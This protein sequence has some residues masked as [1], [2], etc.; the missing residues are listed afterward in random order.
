MSLQGTLKTLGITEVLE[1]LSS[2]SASGRLDVT[3]EMGTASYALVEG[4]VSTA[5]YSF[6][7]ESGVDAAEATYYVVSELDGS[8]Y[9]DDDVP[10]IAD[11]EDDGR[12]DVG[13]VLFRTAEI[14]ERWADVEEVIPSPNHLLTRNNQLDGSVTIQPEWWKALEMIG[15]GATSLQLAS[16]LELGALDASL[17]ALA[18]TKAGLLIV[19]EVDPLDISLGDDLAIPPAE[20]AVDH[21]E[22]PI[23]HAADPA[24]MISEAVDA[25]DDWSQEPVPEVHDTGAP[26]AIDGS[27]FATPPVE[28]AP[29]EPAHESFFGSVVEDEAAAD[30]DSPIFEPV[31]MLE[32]VD[33]EAPAPLDEAPEQTMSFSNPVEEA[34]AP[35]VDEFAGASGMDDLSELEYMVEPDGFSPSVSDDDG[36]SNAHEGS[37]ADL[38]PLAAAAPPADSDEHP[39]VTPPEVP[40][41]PFD[42]I[43]VPEAPS[44]FEAAAAPIPESAAP[45]PETAMDLS[46]LP[47]PPPPIEPPATPTAPIPESGGFS[48][49][50]ETAEPPSATAMAGEVLEDLASLSD[51]LN[52]HVTADGDW[53]LDGTF[54]PEADPAPPTPEGDPFGDLGELLKDEDERSSVLKFLRRD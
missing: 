40:P 1:F 12:E 5:E 36:W 49:V 25:L 53:E 45:I 26:D 4:S 28:E 21:V 31:D 3:T 7:R 19:S 39:P 9:F 33:V 32:M 14:A 16:A 10:E 30:V 13:S 38:R 22:T 6:I 35:E 24:A 48:Q 34:S 43:P 46:D 47:A 27:M 2:R 11:D 23:E 8:F 17:T 42:A 18:M 41:S 50:P 20:G 29:A 44:P 15:E 54:V 51:E 52:E 37:D